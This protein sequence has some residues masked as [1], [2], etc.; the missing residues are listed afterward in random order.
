MNTHASTGCYVEMKDGS[1]VKDTIYVGA[2]SSK[3]ITYPTPLAGSVATAW[4]FDPS[5][6][7]TTI[8]CTVGGY[9]SKV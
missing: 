9:K 4:N 5:A 8:I 6:A 7:V 3:E 2:S 1:T